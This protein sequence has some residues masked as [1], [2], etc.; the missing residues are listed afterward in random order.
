MYINIMFILKILKLVN[1]AHIH[2]NIVGG[3]IAP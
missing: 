2:S 1:N 3:D